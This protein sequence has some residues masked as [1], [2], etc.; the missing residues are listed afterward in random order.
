MLRI[1]RIS[2]KSKFTLLKEAFFSL[3]MILTFSSFVNALQREKAIAKVNE[4]NIVNVAGTEIKAK[5]V[6]SLYGVPKSFTDD[7]KKRTFNYFWE[8][9]DEDTWQ[10]NDRYPSNT[11]ISVVGTGFALPSYI[12][13]I[14]NN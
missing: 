4:A 7:L 5:N 6:D 9:V 12:I 8:V 3:I 14:H 2:Q 11:F 13:G 1:S 10:T